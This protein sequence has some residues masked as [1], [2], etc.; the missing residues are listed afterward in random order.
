MKQTKKWCIAGALFTLVA[1]TLLH[2]VHD[3][4]GGPVT[5]ILGAVNESTWEHLKLLFWP[6]VLFGIVEYLAYGR[7]IKGFLPIKVISLLIGLLTIVTLFY[8]YT[9]IL[10]FN[11]L[12]LDIG[13]FVIGTLA[14]YGYACCR[15]EHPRPALQTRAATVGAGLILVLLL[16][17]F[18]AFTWAPPHI[19]LFLDPVSGGYGIA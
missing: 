3:W 18:I 5:A 13:T 4:C 15:L 1:G 6:V 7:E 9:G 16:A 2:F 12:V 19:G 11:T 8:T 17:G 10:G 14:A